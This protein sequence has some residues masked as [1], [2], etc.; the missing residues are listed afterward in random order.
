MCVSAEEAGV[1]KDCSEKKG[2]LRREIGLR[3]GTLS[4]RGLLVCR[5]S[6]FW[7]RVQLILG[8]AS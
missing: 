4:R 3:I 1:V 8:W 5:F 7:H 6:S 2:L